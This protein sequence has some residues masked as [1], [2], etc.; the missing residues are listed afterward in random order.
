MRKV[1]FEED[2]MRVIS[3][4][5][6]TSREKALAALENVLSFTREDADLSAVVIS[7]VEKLKRISDLE[8]DQLDFEIYRL[9]TEEE[10][11]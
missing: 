10:D 5:D 11:E 4:F 7:A 8:F 9:E 6:T 2:E 1:F 3:M